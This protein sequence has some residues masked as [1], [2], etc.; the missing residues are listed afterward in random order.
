MCLWNCRSIRL[1]YSFPTRLKNSRRI[2]SIITPWFV[3]S[4]YC[5]WDSDSMLEGHNLRWSDKCRSPRFFNQGIYLL[6]MTPQRLLCL[7]FAT[8]KIK[9]LRSIIT[10]SYLH[11]EHLLDLQASMVFQ[12]QSIYNIISYV[13]IIYATCTYRDHTFSATCT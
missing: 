3:L 5:F 4:A 9:S 6:Y 8:M 2:T 1:S 13:G 11:L 12:F 7:L 10:C